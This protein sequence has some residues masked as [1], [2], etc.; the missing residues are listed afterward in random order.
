MK[1]QKFNEKY[2]LDLE[3]DDITVEYA[4]LIIS[5]YI[6]KKN[7]ETLESV[8]LDVIKG[9]DLDDDRAEMIKPELLNYIKNLYNDAKSIRQIH[10]I[11]SDKYNL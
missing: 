3:Y 4:K 1:V 11:E 5:T 10:E 6:D 8:F 7:E 9:D 2:D